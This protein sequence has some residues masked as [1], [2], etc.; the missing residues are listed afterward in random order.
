VRFKGRFKNNRFGN[1]PPMYHLGAIAHCDFSHAKLH[2]VLF[3][4]TTC[5]GVK[6]GSWPQFTITNSPAFHSSIVKCAESNA[7]WDYFRSLSDYV[8][9]Y[10]DDLVTL[11]F[12]TI[13]AETLSKEE[14]FDIDFLR[15][16]VNS[17]DGVV[18]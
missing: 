15:Q 6:F 10:R 4:N 13:N 14:G 7:I 9:E 17:I 8:K 18:S 2:D 16:C 11:N 3:L 1:F 5:E 12:M